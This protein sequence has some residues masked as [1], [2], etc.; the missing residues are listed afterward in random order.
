MVSLYDRIASQIDGDEEK[1]MTRFSL[2]R[3]S[4]Y[5]KGTTM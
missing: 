2:A 3:V 1:K 4:E 5:G